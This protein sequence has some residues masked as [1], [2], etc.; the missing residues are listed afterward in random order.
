MRKR[1][2]RSQRRE[3]LETT[4]NAG[5]AVRV[6]LGAECKEESDA[7]SDS[8]LFFFL[9]LLLFSGR[10]PEQKKKKLSFHL[11]SIAASKKLR[12]RSV[13]GGGDNET[14]VLVHQVPLLPVVD[15]LKLV[16]ADLQ[17]ARN[18]KIQIFHRQ[19]LNRLEA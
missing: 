1:L 4:F 19:R 18:T 10:A 15:H 5:R 7:R 12:Q 3:E 16:E 14:V 9:L 6:G 8:Y 13:L 11:C 17:V 2:L